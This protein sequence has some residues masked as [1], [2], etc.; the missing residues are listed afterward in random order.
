[1]RDDWREAAAG[2][3]N[4]LSIG[5]SRLSEGLAEGTRAAKKREKRR[6]AK[7]LW[8]SLEN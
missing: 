4:L 8:Y 3:Q 2:R 5:M 6:D 7:I 1:L